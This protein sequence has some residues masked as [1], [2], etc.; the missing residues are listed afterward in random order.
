M[1]CSRCGV[2]LAEGA[3]FCVD[4]G[5]MVEESSTESS[6]PATV[7]VCEK[8]RQATAP[9]AHFCPHCGGPAPIP[10]MVAI[11]D[12]GAAA[13][14]A[15]GYQRIRWSRRRS[16]SWTNAVVWAAVLITATAL[17][18]L[19][20]SDN[21]F[22]PEFKAF[23]VTAH[24][25]TITDGSIA[26]KPRG[27][28]SYKVVVPEGA[29]DVEVAGQFEASGRSDDNVQV[30]VLTDGEFVVWQGGYA[31]SPFYDSGPV[32]K[33]DLQA[34]LPS[35]AGTYYLVLSNKASR[36]EK[37]VTLSAG[38]HYGTWLPDSLVSLKQKVWAWF[39]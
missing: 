3:Q 18:W 22:Y 8:C 9:G 6:V 21:R 37:T 28:A 26:I 32:S 7:I 12:G 5:H 2:S 19:V 30:L 31:T 38:L 33:G 39:D 1:F 14:V 20:A 23:L 29:I 15:P 11:A 24:A 35:R 17:V 25:E 27:F 16:R 13:A 34:I 4:C 36:L 10:A